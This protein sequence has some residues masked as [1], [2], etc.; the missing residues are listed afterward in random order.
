MENDQFSTPENAIF[1]LFFL[2][3]LNG[4]STNKT[5][6]ENTRKNVSRTFFYA[7]TPP[8]SCLS[9]FFLIFAT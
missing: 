6:A 3:F 2:I 8:D 5:T 7:K 1:F 4:L 9:V